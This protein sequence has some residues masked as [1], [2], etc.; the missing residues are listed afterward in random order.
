MKK[1]FALLLCLSML[2][3]LAAC[4]KDEEKTPA[5]TAPGDDYQNNLG[6]QPL[7]E[8]DGPKNDV[9]TL[10]ETV[11]KNHVAGTEGKMAIEFDEKGQILKGFN[12]ADDDYVLQAE[13]EFD[14]NGFPAAVTLL[15]DG[16]VWDRVALTWDP[17]GNLLKKDYAEHND[18]DCEYTYN[19]MGAVL[20]EG[21][22]DNYYEY[23]YEADGFVL[24]QRQYRDGVLREIRDYSYAYGLVTECKKSSFDSNGN[25][26]STTKETYDQYGNMTLSRTTYEDETK[27]ASETHYEYTYDDKG[28]M[29]SNDFYRDGKYMYGYT[30]TYDA[31]G[32]CT[33]EWAD[34]ELQYESVYTNGGKNVTT[35]TYKDGDEISSIIEYEYDEQGNELHYLKTKNEEAQNER[36]STYKTFSLTKRQARV[37]EAMLELLSELEVYG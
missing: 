14:S 37:F 17:E 22:A 2:L 15:M 7:W 1:L 4:G 35:T 12:D 32:N 26:Y 36:I 3:A 25:L 8:D 23:V 9:Y 34:G 11:Y 30:Y 10:V 5:G 13:M 18:Q 29:L 20:K 24:S 6:V 19:R 33:A 28:N 27:A 16:D 21:T 31:D